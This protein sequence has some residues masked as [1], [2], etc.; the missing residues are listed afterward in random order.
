MP[1]KTAMQETTCG[2][3]LVPQIIAGAE[4]IS[5]AYATEVPCR[6]EVTNIS[7]EAQVLLGFNNGDVMQLASA[8]EIV[9]TAKAYTLL[10]RST[11]VFLLAPGQ[12]LYAATQGT[13]VV[14][15]TTQVSEA[16][17]FTV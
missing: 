6:V 10:Q 11:R 14:Q 9:S 7:Q 15:V 2:T 17:P 1:S 3:Y 8:G 5:I 12:K 16:F 4:P 13:G